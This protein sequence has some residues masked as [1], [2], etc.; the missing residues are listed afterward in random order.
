MR[1]VLKPGGSADEAFET[2][3][4]SV[5]EGLNENWGPNAES[6]AKDVCPVSKDR[7]FNPRSSSFG[8]LS[9]KPLGSFGPTGKTGSSARAERL[10][11]LHGMDWR[12]RARSINTLTD[13]QFFEGTGGR[14]GQTPDIIEIQYGTVRGAFAHKPGTLRDSIQWNKAKR[15]GKTLIRG[16][17]VATARYAGHV[18][19]GRGP[20]NR[21]AK[22]F[23]TQAAG[24]LLGDLSDLSTFEG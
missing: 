6:K 17:L 12:E 23:L 19:E 16:E 9:L 24:L 14:R 21:E 1:I 8:K 11:E 7:P 22:P 2:A 4:S 3:V 13:S 15:V 10:L 20:G 5:L 18:H